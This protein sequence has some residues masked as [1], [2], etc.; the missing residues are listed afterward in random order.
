VLTLEF[1]K[2]YLVNCYVPAAGERMERLNY[3]VSEYQPVFYSFVNELSQDK[4]VVIVGD[5]NV[6]RC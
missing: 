3:K 2:F 1:E 6:A 4:D 5:L